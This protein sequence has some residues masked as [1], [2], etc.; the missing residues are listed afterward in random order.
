[1]NTCKECKDW[2]SSLPHENSDLW[3]AN[4]ELLR[5]LA[6]GVEFQNLSENSSERLQSGMNQSWKSCFQCELKC[7]KKG[8]FLLIKLQKKRQQILY[9]HWKGRSWWRWSVIHKKH[10]NRPNMKTTAKEER[11]RWKWK[12]MGDVEANHIDA[13]VGIWKDMLHLQGQN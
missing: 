6:T 9:F 3:T 4:Y 10:R 5:W 2:D 8:A 12:C 11:A 13:V 1:M 7:R